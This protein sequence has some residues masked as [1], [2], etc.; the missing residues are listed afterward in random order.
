[1]HNS[2]LLQISCSA[3]KVADKR[4]TEHRSDHAS[5]AG[6]R[7]KKAGTVSC[8]TLAASAQLSSEIECSPECS[9]QQYVALI[10][11]PLEELKAF[12]RQQTI[13]FHEHIFLSITSFC[14]K[15]LLV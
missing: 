1:M 5:A 13:N 11:V 4:K 12:C 15:K 14:S 3:A 8:N 7:N 6:D 9:K 10:Q 2:I